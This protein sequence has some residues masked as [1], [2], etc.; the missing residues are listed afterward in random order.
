MTSPSDE[1]SAA[2]STPLTVAVCSVTPTA[3]GR[4]FWAAWWTGAPVHAPVFRKPDASSG[5]ART[6]EE[7]RRDAEKTTGRALQPIE[8]YWAR[9]WNRVLRGEPAPK[10]PAERPRRPPPAPTGP[11]SAWEILELEPGASLEEVRRSHRRLALRLHPDRGGDV[12]AFREMQR[13]YERL[14]ARLTR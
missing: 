7:A 11:R 13:A 8:G 2:P 10:P 3:R 4:Y 9:A 1:T 12:E 5:G 14:R 6:E